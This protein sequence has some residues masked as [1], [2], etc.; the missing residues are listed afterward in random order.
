MTK[1][2]CLLNTY[3]GFVSEVHYVSAAPMSKG[4]TN[5]DILGGEVF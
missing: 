4:T 5:S 1:Y 2:L 3:I